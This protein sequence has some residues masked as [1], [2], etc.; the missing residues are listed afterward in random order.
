MGEDVKQAV[1]TVPAYFNDSQRQAT[2]DAVQIAG[3]EVLRIIN[4]P[5]AA[6]VAYGLDRKNDETILVF[7]LGG[8]TFDVSVLEVGDGVIEVKSTNGDTHLGGDDWDERI[9]HWLFEEFKKE[10]GIDLSQD[11]Q[12]LQRLR[13]AAEKAKIELSSTPQTEINLP[14]IT[15]DSSGPKHLAMT[16][17]RSKFEQLTADLVE[18]CK[19]PF[20]HA[21]KPSIFS[22]PSASRTEP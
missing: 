19:Q 2:K 4:E 3:L 22:R 6:A 10:Q 8:G 15:A 11:R 12:A 20:T 16:L 9:V 1:I 5:T 17:S 13:E 7:D 18:R 14:Y 21:L